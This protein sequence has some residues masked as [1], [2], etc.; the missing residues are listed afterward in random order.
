[1]SAWLIIALVIL[2]LGL[3]IGLVDPSLLLLFC[4]P[5]LAI[6]GIIYGLVKLPAW[7]LGWTSVGMVV[8]I[9][10]MAMPYLLMLGIVIAIIGLSIERDIMFIIGVGIIALGVIAG[11]VA[12]AYAWIPST[13]WRIATI[14]IVPLVLAFICVC[15]GEFG[16]GGGSSESN[17][18]F[19]SLSDGYGSEQC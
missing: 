7:V 17:Y 8:K 6:E 18:S 3:L 13:G 5:A 2:G 4:L 10:F 19:G 15:A 16:D 9:A 12:A 14:V 1:M 11:V